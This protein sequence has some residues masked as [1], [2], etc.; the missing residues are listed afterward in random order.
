MNLSFNMSEPNT[1]IFPLDKQIVLFLSQYD[2]Q[3]N[4]KSFLEEYHKSTEI[5]AR[6]VSKFFDP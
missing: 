6:K 3:V 2:V 1:E 4:Y 5:K